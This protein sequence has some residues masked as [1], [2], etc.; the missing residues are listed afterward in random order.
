MQSLEFAFAIKTKTISPT[1]VHAYPAFQL[2]TQRLLPLPRQNVAVLLATRSVYRQDS[3][4]VI[5][6]QGISS[7]AREFAHLAL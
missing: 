7:A 3:V 2:F 4:F 1:M 6:I 5:K